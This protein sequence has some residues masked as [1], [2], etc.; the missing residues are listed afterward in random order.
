MK[1]LAIVLSGLLFFIIFTA[2]LNPTAQSY[3]MLET[4]LNIN[5]TASATVA[6]PIHGHKTVSLQGVLLTGIFTTTGQVVIERSN[7]G[8]D[9][10]VG[11][12][13]ERINGPEIM[14]NMNVGVRF[15][16]ARTLQ[17]QGATGVARLTIIAK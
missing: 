16:R 2:Q 12:T 10:Q 5:S 4:D 7:N 6:L 11:T 13:G 9:W 15:I 8:I 14:D 17:A 1:Y 3:V